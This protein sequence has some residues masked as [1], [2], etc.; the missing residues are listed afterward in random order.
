MLPRSYKLLKI[1]NGKIAIRNLIADSRL[2][3]HSY[4][5]TGILETLS[6]NIPTLAFWQNG[7]DHLREEVR[8][9]YQKLIDAG[10]IHLSARS[11]ADKVNEIWNDVDHWW[12]NEDLQDARNQF[13]NIYAKTCKNPIKTMVSFFLEKDI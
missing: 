3:V 10:I 8:P 2:V 6:Q 1:D 12:L 7:L 5:S 4:D 13:C 9:D 11:V